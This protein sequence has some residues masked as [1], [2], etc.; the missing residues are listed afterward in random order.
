[1]HGNHRLFNNKVTF[2]ILMNYF[3]REQ[4]STLNSYQN[5]LTILY[6][7]TCNRKKVIK[8]KENIYLFIYFVYF[9]VI[10]NPITL[11]VMCEGHKF[12]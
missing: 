1:M 9:M 3:S 10:S 5:L 7:D 6:T 11:Q 12:I 2:S 8:L 4:C